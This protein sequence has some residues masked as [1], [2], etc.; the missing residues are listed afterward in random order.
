MSYPMNEVYVGELDPNV[1]EELLFS[2]FSKAGRIHSMKVM[3][4]IVTG[5]SRG[6]AFINFFTYNEACRAQKLMDGEKF[7]GRKIK[8]YLKAEYD[9]LDQNANVIFQNLP[10]TVTDEEVTKLVAPIANPFS[11]RIVKNDKK[12]DEA[13]AFVQFATMEAATTAI[14]KL[15]GSEF[16]GKE[17]QVELTNKK[18][19]VFIK[20]RHHEGAMA[21]L[22]AQLA[23]WK[24]EESES[25]ELS[26]DKSSFI[27]LLRFDTETSAQNFLEDYRKDPKKCE[28]TRPDHRPRRRQ[29]QPQIAQGRLRKRHSEHGLQDHSVQ[30]RLCLA[31]VQ[32]GNREAVRPDCLPQSELI[33]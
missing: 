26:S 28:L 3:R 12:P 21:E 18:N 2:A 5:A 9:A 7:F 22:R 11:V 19:R 16:A 6:F 15:N 25:P 13:K 1:N 4:H 8:V 14:E 17:L 32:G 33:S 10:S 29:G 30:G 24:F 27:V 31:Q 23:E 20:A